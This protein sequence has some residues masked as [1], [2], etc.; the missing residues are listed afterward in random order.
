MASTS[1]IGI[2]HQLPRV[3]QCATSSESRRGLPSDQSIDHYDSHRKHNIRTAIVKNP[4]LQNACASCQSRN[5]A[6]NE[7]GEFICDRRELPPAIADLMNQA[8][9]GNPL[10]RCRSEQFTVAYSDDASSYRQQLK[11]WPVLPGQANV[12][13][14]LRSTNKEVLD[15]CPHFSRT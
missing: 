4:C 13:G 9:A 14:M 8:Y 6:L 11:L 3:F 1:D 2:C 10:T 7:G 5:I 15:C 12:S